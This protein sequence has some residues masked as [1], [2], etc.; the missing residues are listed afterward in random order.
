MRFWEFEGNDPTGK[1]L[2]WWMVEAGLQ[3]KWGKVIAALEGTFGSIFTLD[4]G[5][6]TWPRY[7]IA[8][9]PKNNKGEKPGKIQEKIL[10]FLHEINETY[11]YIHHPLLLDIL[12]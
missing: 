12:T 8:K 3:G 7:L 6:H 1:P 2:R 5:E 10:H 11:K 4:Q 9:A